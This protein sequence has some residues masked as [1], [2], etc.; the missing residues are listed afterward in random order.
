VSDGLPAEVAGL[1]T[2]RGE[3]IRAGVFETPLGDVER[4]TGRAPVAIEQFL[5]ED[6]VG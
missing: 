1:L 6:R 5:A 4:S 3:R 2:G